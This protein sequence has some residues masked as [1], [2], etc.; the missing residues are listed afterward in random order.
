MNSSGQPT[1]HWPEQ[2][3]SGGQTGVDRAALEVAMDLGWMHGGWCPAGRLAEDGTVPSRYDLKEHES[4][5][6]PART[7][8]NVVDSDA[9]LI[10]YDS[11]LRGGTLLTRRFARKH[12]KPHFTATLQAH[13]I[14]EVRDWLNEIKPRTLNVAGPRESNCPGIQTRTISYLHSVFTASEF[15]PSE[16][17]EQA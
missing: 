2:I 13:T 1:I 9:T 6:Y 12:T 10:L 7:E 17:D 5:A 4:T 16:L 11:D 8:Q 15:L 3:V 14:S